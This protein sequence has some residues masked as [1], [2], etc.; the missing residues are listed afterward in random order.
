MVNK[1]SFPLESS[2]S[3]VAPHRGPSILVEEEAGPCSPELTTTVCFYRVAL[4][5]V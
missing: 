3:F 1:T 4:L 5:V 2:I